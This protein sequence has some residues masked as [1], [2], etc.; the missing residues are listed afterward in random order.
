MLSIPLA[1]SP[2][3]AAEVPRQLRE[4]VCIPDSCT[5]RIFKQCLE[6]GKRSSHFLDYDTTINFHQ[7]LKALPEKILLKQL[8]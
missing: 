6:Q 8:I 7:L 2:W 3:E 1:C 5:T 4:V